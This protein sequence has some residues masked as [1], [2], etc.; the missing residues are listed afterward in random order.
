MYFYVITPWES[1]QYTIC[2]DN[3]SKKYSQGIFN[4]IRLNEMSKD[5]VERWQKAGIAIYEIQLFF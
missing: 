4:C 5:S 3:D 1:C 2:D